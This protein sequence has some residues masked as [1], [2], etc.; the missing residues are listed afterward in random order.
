[1]LYA[2]M[3]IGLSIITGVLNIPNFAHGALFALGAY[4]L[5][6]VIQLV[7]NFW[8]A[9]VLAPL[10]VGVLGVLIEYGGIRPLYRA[11]HDYQLLLTFGLSLILTEGIII[12]WRPV[13]VSQ[14]PPPLLPRRLR[15]GITFFPENRLLL[16]VAA[17]PL[18]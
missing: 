3:G 14:L 7:G 18:Q 16:I 9:L 17:P 1:M 15:P 10:G 11:G 13:G 2:L 12:L 6:S 5:Y 4:F 8:L